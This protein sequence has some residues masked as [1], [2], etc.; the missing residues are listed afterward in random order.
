MKNLLHLNK[1]LL[2]YKTLLIIG[3][4]FILISNIFALYPAEFVRHAFDN[5]QENLNQNNESNLYIIHYKIWRSYYFIYNH[6]R[7]FHVF[8]ETNCNCNE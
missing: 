8:Y 2:K 7:S 5:I 4:I 3:A 6:E 1:Y